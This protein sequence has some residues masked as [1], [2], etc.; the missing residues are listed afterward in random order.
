MMVVP[1][2]TIVALWFSL[3]NFWEEKPR[4]PHLTPAGQNT[5]IWN[6]YPDNSVFYISTTSNTSRKNAICISGNRIQHLLLP[7]VI[8]SLKTHV[9]GLNDPDIFIYGFYDGDSEVVSYQLLRTYGEYLKGISM[10]KWYPNVLFI[11]FTPKGLH[12]RKAG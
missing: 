8:E 3:L 6:V 9:L 2:I 7:D 1:L 5:T 12:G 4:G 11:D 10:K